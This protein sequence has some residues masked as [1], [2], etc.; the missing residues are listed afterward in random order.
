MIVLMV[1]GACFMFV[2]AINAIVIAEDV[3]GCDIDLNEYVSRNKVKLL[4]M[5]WV[6][7]AF[8]A[9][10]ALVVWAC[11]VLKGV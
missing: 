2:T 9:G 3:N 10:A 1:F 7:I 5:L 4:A 8:A 6:A 11:I